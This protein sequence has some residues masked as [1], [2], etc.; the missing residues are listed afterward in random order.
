[1]LSETMWCEW[2]KQK[3]RKKKRGRMGE[4]TRELGYRESFERS[5]EKKETRK[6]SK[7]T[8]ERKRQGRKRRRRGTSIS[9]ET[10]FHLLCFCSSDN[11]GRLP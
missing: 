3:R 2:V 4:R 9:K 7:R 8:L 11:N 10:T 1:M 5:V 6:Q